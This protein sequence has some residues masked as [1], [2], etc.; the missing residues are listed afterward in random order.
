M[1][2]TRS[3]FSFLFFLVVV[4]A[5]VWALFDGRQPIRPLDFRGSNIKQ[6][7]LLATAAA[8]IP[9]STDLSSRGRTRTKGQKIEVSP[10]QEKEKK[11]KLLFSSLFSF[12]H[13][14]VRC[15]LVRFVHT[16]RGRLCDRDLCAVVVQRLTTTTTTPTTATTTTFYSLIDFC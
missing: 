1:K 14:S 16:N 9:Y 4:V 15:R 12:S 13:R 7:T 2:L 6:S 5:T 10:T 3:F 11:K 8:H